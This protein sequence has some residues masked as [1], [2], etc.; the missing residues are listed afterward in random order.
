MSIGK[1]VMFVDAKV[2]DDNKNEVG[3]NE[4]GELAIRAKKCHTWLLE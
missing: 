1:A 4:I 3:L 2:L